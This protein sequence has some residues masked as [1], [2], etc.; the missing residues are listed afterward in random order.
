M[1]PMFEGTKY[2]LHVPDM[3]I[4]SDDCLT[5]VAVAAQWILLKNGEW[6]EVGIT[7]GGIH[8]LDGDGTGNTCIPNESVYYAYSTY[9]PF[10][11]TT[12]YQEHT[13]FQSI[14]VGDILTFEIKRGPFD[15]NWQIF[16]NERSSYPIVSISLGDNEGYAIQSGLEST[17]R[18]D[19]YSSIGVSKFVD[20]KNLQD[21]V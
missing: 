14:D 1:E 7:Q 3:F 19:Q 16:W 6:L 2:Q 12:V 5:N 4:K 9:D 8:D 11:M 15:K 18:A 10:F 21:G 20:S 13:I 17:L